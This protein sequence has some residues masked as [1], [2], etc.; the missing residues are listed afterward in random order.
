MGSMALPNLNVQSDGNRVDRHSTSTAGVAGAYSGALSYKDMLSSF[1][2]DGGENQSENKGGNNK[3]AARGSVK[4]QASGSN[5]SMSMLNAL[6]LK[7]TDFPMANIIL[8]GQEAQKVGENGVA[9]MENGFYTTSEIEIDE[10]GKVI[11]VE[12]NHYGPGWKSCRGE[13]DTKN[14]VEDVVINKNKT[15]DALATDLVKYSNNLDADQPVITKMT[16]DGVEVTSATA[17]SDKPVFITMSNGRMYVNTQGSFAVGNSMPI[18][19]TVTV[20]D[21]DGE[22][23]SVPVYLTKTGNGEWM[24]SINS[25]VT[26]SQAD[27]LRYDETPVT[28]NMEPTKFTFDENGNINKS[29][30]SSAFISYKTESGMHV[31]LLDLS[32]VTQHAGKTSINGASNGYVGGYLEELNVNEEGEIVGRYSNG[33]LQV[34]G[35]VVMP[36]STFETNEVQQIATKSNDVTL[37]YN[38][39]TIDENELSFQNGSNGWVKLSK[40]VTT[41]SFLRIEKIIIPEIKSPEDKYYVESGL[42]YVDVYRGLAVNYG[43]PGLWPVYLLAHIKGNVKLYQEYDGRFLLSGQESNGAIG[44]VNNV[45][46][47]LIIGGND[48]NTLSSYANDVDIIGGEGKNDIK[49]NGANNKVKG[50]DAGDKILLTYVDN[51]SVNCGI[52]DDKIEINN[53]KNVTV[54]LNKGNNEADVQRSENITISGDIGK[55]LFSADNS[56]NLIIE[57]GNQGDKYIIRLVDNSNVN[58][59]EGDDELNIVDSH[60]LNIN[61]GEGENYIEIDAVKALG[62][63]CGSGN[64]K[65]HLHDVDSVSVDLNGGKNIVEISKGKNTVIEGGHD[66]DTFNIDS[67]SSSKINCGNGNDTI[68][69]SEANNLKINL[70]AGDNT[71]VFS[72]DDYLRAYDIEITGVGA[73]KY[74]IDTSK[75]SYFQNVNING[76][77]NNDELQIVGDN[78]CFSFDE[79]NNTFVIYDGDESILSVTNITGRNARV[80]VNGVSST[81]NDIIMEISDQDKQMYKTVGENGS[82]ER[83]IVSA[84][85]KEI[86]E[87]EGN[88]NESG[89]LVPIDYEETIELWRKERVVPDGTVPMN[90]WFDPNIWSNPR[91]Y[92]KQIEG[93][94]KEEVV[95]TGAKLFGNQEFVASVKNSLN[96]L[97]LGISNINSKASGNNDDNLLYELT[98]MLDSVTDLS[99]AYLSNK[100]KEEKRKDIEKASV[101]CSE[102]GLTLLKALLDKWSDDT[103]VDKPAIVSSPYVRGGLSVL[104]SIIGVSASLANACDGWDDKTSKEKASDYV[105]VLSGLLDVGKESY[106]MVDEAVIAFRESHGLLSSAGAQVKTGVWSPLD[107]WTSIGK[108]AIESLVQF[109]ES[110]T[111]YSKDGSID[112]RDLGA[113]NVEMAA[114]GFKGILNGLTFGLDEFVFGK[115]YD[116]KLAKNIISTSETLGTVIGVAIVYGDDIAELSH[117]VKNAVVGTLLNMK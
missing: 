77:D 26:K 64:D 109:S 80:T 67:I 39:P 95:D 111:E 74:T 11:S 48:S 63:N 61:L 22:K 52:G 105:N 46:G 47:A 44:I 59:G 92:R 60:D 70:G 69:I 9:S 43:P 99:M 96:P 40:G 88:A 57:G 51:S 1:M 87:F 19:T 115:D 104:S 113:T 33:V 13:I 58:C 85:E 55:N 71:V 84:N 31:V 116:Q 73:N 82:D 56:K 108:G 29:N 66:G 107:V 102:S 93:K 14:Q 41:S 106:E 83:T 112:V 5:D 35:K 101:E 7:T 53:G 78:P 10:N 68:N 49:I 28:F 62:I 34:E 75:P 37:H 76:F 16:Q 24:A 114:A 45:H 79:T 86:A 18:T 32:G 42:E 103:F 23:Y 100:T 15:I 4:L 3:S 81:L 38:E 50:G 110:I 17:S 8:G 94:R 97:F 25:D 98:K 117:L 27:I 2:N 72:S 21:G 36:E 91:E 54:N 20:Y 89:D 12:K 90:P 30:N 6:S 65:L